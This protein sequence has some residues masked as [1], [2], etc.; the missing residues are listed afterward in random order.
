MVSI[1]V[2]LEGTKCQEASIH[3]RQSYIA[4]GAPGEAIVFHD[5]DG[6][7]AYIMCLP[8]AWHNIENRG[9]KLLASANEG[10]IKQHGVL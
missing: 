2:N 6:R 8:C 10:L 9:A 5:R 1:Y 3:S 4:C 7:Q